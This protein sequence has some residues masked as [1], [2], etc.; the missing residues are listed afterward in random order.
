MNNIVFIYIEKESIMGIKNFEELRK[1]V[2][3][4]KKRTVIVIAAH[5]AHTLEAVLKTKEECILDYILVGK[6]SEIIK[7]GKKFGYDIEKSAIVDSDTDEDAVAKGIAL[8]KD[9]KGDFIQK[10]ILQ[11]STLLKGVVDKETGIRQGG[12]ISHTA[13]LDIPTYH[14][15]VGLTDG[16]MMMYPTLEQKKDIIDNAVSVFHGLGYDNPKVAVLA[17]VEVLNPKMPETVDATELKKM[18]EE[19]EIKG[20]TVEGP[21]SFDLAMDKESARIK[22]YESPVAGDADIL[23][24][25]DIAAGNLM[26]KALYVLGGARMAGLVVGAKCPIALN[27]RSASFEEKYYSLLAC[28]YMTSK[29][30]K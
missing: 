12:V 16:G 29:D 22:K 7:I 14:K 30:N 9:G 19:G 10:G 17:A 20:C 25:P 2:A 18:N 5:D 4:A 1:L 21:I 8:I 26:S 3:E 28:A 24:A 13:L 6:E 15:I 11:T 27:S 23:V